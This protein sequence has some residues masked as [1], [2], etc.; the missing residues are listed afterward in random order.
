MHKNILTKA[1]STA[2]LSTLAFFVFPSVAA[3]QTAQPARGGKLVG[4]IVERST[5]LPLPAE[6]GVTVHSTGRMVLK[7]AAAS[8]Q[9]E[10]VIDG[11]EA[12]KIHLVTKLDGYAAE[13]QN[14]ALGEGE[15]KYVEFFL[16]K[17][18]LVRGVISGPNGKPLPGASVKVLYSA[19]PPARGEVRTSYQWET[20]ETLSDKLGNYVI[21]VN[22]ET[23][24]V[25]EV[26]HPALMG[27]VSPPKR[28]KAAEREALVS[29]SLDRGITVAGE[30]RDEAGNVVPG[31]QVR[32]F[33]VG[34]KQSVPGFTSHELLK[35]NMRFTASGPD[36]AFK[37][38]QARASKKMLV[39]VHPGYK[40]FKQVVDL[41]PAQA[42]APLKVV[43]SAK[44]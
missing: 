33:E 38:A 40:P 19:P 9:G 8:A 43:L 17:V 16:V 29:L 14:V 32:L 24:F 7:H 20:G 36:G 1:L 31:A 5:N 25:L 4:R 11:L 10:F 44:Q 28:I 12:G 3:A 41:T 18:K 6:V 35:Q 15:T 26:S 39:V 37:F 21:A 23:D 13:H 22:P 2:A 34:S 27:A 42:Q 30:V